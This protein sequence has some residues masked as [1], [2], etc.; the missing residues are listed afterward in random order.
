MI[1]L[2]ESYP[3]WPCGNAIYKF[4]EKPRDWF[5]SGWALDSVESKK[6][7][8]YNA[9]INVKK[10]FGTIQCEKCNTQAR[11]KIKQHGKKAEEQ[12]NKG[13]SVPTCDGMFFLHIRFDCNL[14]I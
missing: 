6:N 3:H 13:C 8:T 10:C 4:E 12:L 11:P 7:T 2:D 9:Q 1:F 5:Q 14:Y